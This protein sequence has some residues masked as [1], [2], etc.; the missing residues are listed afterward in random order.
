MGGGEVGYLTS[1]LEIVYV[2]ILQEKMPQGKL[3]MGKSFRWKLSQGICQEPEIV[4]YI[5]IATENVA[6]RKMLGGGKLHH[7][8]GG[9]QMWNHIL[10]LYTFFN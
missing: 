10:H 7:F 4:Q 8:M 5:A 9:L 2:V 3:S 1:W 6:A